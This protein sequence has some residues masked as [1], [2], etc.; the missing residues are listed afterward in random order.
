MQQ[1]VDPLSRI[2]GLLVGKEEDLDPFGGLHTKIVDIR[3]QLN[4]MVVGYMML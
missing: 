2:T 3:E 4:L 1:S